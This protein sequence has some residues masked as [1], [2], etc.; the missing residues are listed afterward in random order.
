[1]PSGVPARTNEPDATPPTDQSFQ[2]HRVA[3]GDTLLDIARKYG[4]TQEQLICVNRELRRNPNLLSIG[5]E[6]GTW[7][8]YYE[9]PAPSKT[10][11]ARSRGGSPPGDGTPRRVAASPAGWRYLGVRLMEVILPASTR[12]VA[13]RC[14]DGARGRTTTRSTS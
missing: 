12:N 8:P 1:M 4:V 2:T 10:K 3:R 13:S 11:S 9:C 5:Q 7:P 14:W 6:L